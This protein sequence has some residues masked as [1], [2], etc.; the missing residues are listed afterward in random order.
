MLY[1]EYVYPA[2]ELSG[3][4]LMLC[5]AFLVDTTGVVP[6]NTFPDV[7]TCL[8]VNVNVALGSTVYL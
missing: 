1:V 2:I 8:T 4:A 6:G 3:I 7:S 5:S